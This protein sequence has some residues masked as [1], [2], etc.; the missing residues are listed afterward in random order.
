[1]HG[2]RHA[3]IAIRVPL[4]NLNNLDFNLLK[5]LDALL[6]ERSVTRAAE[7]LGRSQPAVSNSLQR[8]RHVL[9]DE[10]L[11]RGPS[12]FVLTPRADAIRAPLREAISLV[13]GC[14]V[15]EAQ[16]DPAQ[17]AGVF[18][19]STP[20]RLSLALV[21]PLFARLQR[22]AP[23]MSLQIVTAEHQQA[24]DLLDADRTDLALGWLDE[25]PSHL[26][27]EMVHEENLFCIFRRDHPILKRGATFDIATVLSFPHLMVSATGRRTA[28]FDDLLLRHGLRRHALVAVTNFTLVPHLLGSSDMIGVFTKLAAD[29]FQKSFKLAKRPVPIDVGKIATKMVWRVRD[30][31][32]KKHLWL[33]QQI[34]AVYRGF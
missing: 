23:N 15:G 4:V 24:L 18:R 16:F 14:V 19:L 8:L 26:N 27:V 10:L 20:D 3:N 5:V 11:V 9:S 12:G 7:K 22:L 13:E 25:K 33:R 31:K 6:V 28:I 30:D 29:V 17:A 2:I 21:P 32:D 1:M 34:K